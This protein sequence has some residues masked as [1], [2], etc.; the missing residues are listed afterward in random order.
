VAVI[1]WTEPLFAAGHWAPDL[2]RRAGGVDVLAT[3]GEHSRERQ[4]DEVRASD[5]EFLIVAPCGYSLDRSERAAR[6]LLGQTGWEWA[7]SRH[8]WA[9]DANRLLSR[10]GPG[11]VDGALTLAS[12]FHPTLFPAPDAASA[13]RVTVE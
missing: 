10:P 9:L 12:I 4:L 13:R 6:E 8:T 1:E 2:V 7:K 3:A 5:P 11:L